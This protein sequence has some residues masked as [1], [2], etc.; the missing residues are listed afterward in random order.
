MNAALIFPSGTKHKAYR[1]FRSIPQTCHEE[2][3]TAGSCGL[4]GL[5]FNVSIADRSRVALVTPTQTRNVVV[6]SRM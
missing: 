5:N 4:L 6:I 1:R 3:S 2:R